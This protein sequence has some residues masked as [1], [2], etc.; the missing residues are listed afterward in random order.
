MRERC[1]SSVVVVAGAGASDWRRKGAEVAEAPEEQVPISQL[2]AGLLLEWAD[3]DISAQRLQSHLHHS[4]QDSESMGQRVHPM[5]QRL[6]GIGAGEHALRGLRSELESLGL[7]ALQTRLDPPQPV[8]AMR[9][10]STMIQMIFAHYPDRATEIFGADTRILRAFWD[11]FLTREATREWS[12]RL[13]ALR[14]KAPADLVTTVP[15]VLHSDA[16]PCTK[17]RSANSVSWSAL[18]GSGPEKVSKIQIFTHLKE[19]NRGD[20]VAWARVLQD[21]EALA[22]GVVGGATVAQQGRRSFK[23]TVLIFKSDEEVHANELGMPHFGA[24]DMCSDCLANRSTRPFTD[25]REA[26]AWRPTERMTYEGWL[27]RMRLPNHVLVASPFNCS[28]FSFYLDLMHLVGCDG[29]ASII[30]GSALGMALELRA[31]GNNKQQRLNRV[32]EFR[33]NWYNAHPRPIASQRSASRT[34]RV[35]GGGASWSAPR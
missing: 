1:R 34:S 22:T 2:A 12:Q 9:L 19:D 8:Q 31:L 27:A 13:P 30:L 18:L 17:T 25:L 3:G 15:Y 21:F 4:Q 33:A 26:A 7:V 29:V 11:Q 5:V 28:R 23:F 32:N 6:A 24:D 14:G 35:T 16:G 10:P 20:Q